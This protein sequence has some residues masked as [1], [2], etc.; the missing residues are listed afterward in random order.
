MSNREIQRIGLS[1]SR[2]RVLSGGSLLLA[3]GA[4]NLSGCARGSSTH[5]GRMT[6][7]PIDDQPLQFDVRE[8]FARLNRIRRKHWLEELSLDPRLQQAAQDYANLMGER[9]LYGHEIGPGTDFRTRIFN[10]GFTNSAGENI[11]VGYRSIDEALA[12]WMDSPAHRKNMLKRRY[13]VA[14]L[15]YGFNTSG[16]NPR[17]THFWV[18]ILGT[19]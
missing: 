9:G 15:A 4:L 14:G 10:A 7:Q 19:G 12:G 16:K 3:G 6:R 18:L 1:V 8:G 5:A 2:R 17:Y 11:G 13:D